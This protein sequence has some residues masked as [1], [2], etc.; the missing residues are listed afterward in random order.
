MYY[1]ICFVLYVPFSTILFP[2]LNPWQDVFFETA[3][4]MYFSDVSPDGCLSASLLPL[5]Q[6]MQEIF[7]YSVGHNS[8]NMKVLMFTDFS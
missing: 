7:P 8:H 3:L 2:L 6:A 1:F 5:H 4:Q